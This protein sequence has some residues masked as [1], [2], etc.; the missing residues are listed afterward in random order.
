MNS[1]QECTRELMKKKLICQVSN[2]VENFYW[3]FGFRQDIQDINKG[4]DKLKVQ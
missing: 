4:I 2:S 3:C 1:G